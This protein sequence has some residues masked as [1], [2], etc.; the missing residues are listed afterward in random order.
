MSN[1]IAPFILQRPVFDAITAAGMVLLVITMSTA[2]VAVLRR[3]S[4]RA[5][6]WATLAISLMVAANIAGDLSGVFSRLDLQPPPFVLL[7]LLGL[8]LVAAVGLG[9][10]GKVGDVLVRCMSVEALVAMQMFRFPLELLM[11]RAA[12][13]GIMPRE[14][15]M[16]GYNW[17]VLTGLG[18][19]VISVYCAWTWRLPLRVI[20][21]WN[22]FGIACLATIGVLAALTSPNI[23]VFDTNPEHIN[24]W[25]LYF[26]YS[27]LPTLLVV[28]ALFGHV[29]LTRKL[30]YQQHLLPPLHWPTLRKATN[31]PW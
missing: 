9:Y 22:I 10:L 14:F 1:P 29:L 23:H 11:L 17:D 4:A 8:G 27:M 30:I 2:W 5:A 25:V 31:D 6:L 21:L 19:L 24:S 16:L 3:R 28:Y 18:A 20:W 12:Y 15:S 7:V 26:P 13:L